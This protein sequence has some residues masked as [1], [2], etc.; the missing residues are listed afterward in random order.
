MITYSSS[1]APSINHHQT[2]SE[3]GPTFLPKWGPPRTMSAAC[4]GGDVRRCVWWVHEYMGYCLCGTKDAMAFALGMVSLVAWGVAEIPQ[5]VTNYQ[6]KS[7]SGLSFTFLFTWTIGD[8]F[9][10]VGCMLEPASIP[11]QYY[12]ALLYTATTLVLVL[13]CIYYEHIYHW[14]KSSKLLDKGTESS[15]DQSAGRTSHDSHVD[16]KFMNG[17]DTRGYMSDDGTI[18]SSPIPFVPRSCSA[19]PETYYISARSLSTSRTPPL[20]LFLA[21]KR[22]GSTDNVNPAEEPLLPS[23][24]PP[25]TLPHSKKKTMMCVISV[26]T[27]F[28]GCFNTSRIANRNQG[29]VFEMPMQLKRKLLQEN[30]VPLVNS[31]I[32]NNDALGTIFGWGM[33]VIYLG[34]RLPQIFLNI[35][36][37]NVEGLNPWM[38][39]FA[40]VGNAAYVASILVNSLKWS[41]IRPNFPWLV[42]AG[43]CVILDIFILVQFAFFH[44]R[45]SKYLVIKQ[46]I[47]NS[48]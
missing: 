40:L 3:T 11:T 47:D 16:E 42:D 15:Q 25:P 17:N 32:G 21:P 36:R 6:I 4:G 43:G 18:P 19:G 27:F 35:K 24:S 5:I 44:Q 33:A 22:A 37:G 13:Q 28:A 39:L 45:E 9:N 8:L 23:S 46:G 26:V 38:F 31:G 7:T 41:T 12:T 30:H 48:A 1:T 10:L 2:K 34:G 14:L 29:V 20:G